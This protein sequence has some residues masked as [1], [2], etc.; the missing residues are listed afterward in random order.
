[1]RVVGVWVRVLSAQVT[2]S[3]VLSVLVG[4]LNDCKH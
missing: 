2:V 3:R 4:V 1:M